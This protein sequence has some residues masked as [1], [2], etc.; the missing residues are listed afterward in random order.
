MEHLR[1]DV[2]GAL[3]LKPEEIAVSLIVPTHNE[4]RGLR[5]LLPA[6]P[7]VVDEIIIVDWASTD[8][9]RDV[10]EYIRPDAIVVE[11]EGRGKG[12]AIKQGLAL[13]KGH[14]L[15]TCDGDGSMDPL[16]M[17]D[18]LNMLIGDN[19]DF[20][21]G[22]RCKPGGGSSDFTKWRNFGNNVLTWCANQIADMNW[23]DITYGFNAYHRRVMPV[24][25]GL[26]D[27]FA[28]E[29]QLAA[30]LSRSDFKIGEFTSWESPRVGGESKLNSIR[31]GLRILRVLIHERNK[32]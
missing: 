10:I 29:I 15:V 1:I 27:G 30:R 3:G 4:A 9:S 16:D 21:K 31:D 23:T 22:S 17:L 13:A 5:R 11:Q 28:F 32:A 26:A 7:S 19:F 8:D 20:V 25:E 24:T 2:H 18:A 12:A 6:I 14:I